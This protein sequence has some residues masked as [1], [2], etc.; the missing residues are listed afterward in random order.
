MVQQNKGISVTVDF[1]FEDMTDSELVMI[2]F[3]E[4]PLYWIT[5]MMTR[6]GSVPN[7]DVILFGKH[8]LK[9]QENIQKNHILR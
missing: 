7:A 2:P 6:A 1:I 8:V 9:W 5:Y 3:D 4:E